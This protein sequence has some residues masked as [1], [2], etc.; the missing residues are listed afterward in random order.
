MEK[1]IKIKDVIVESNIGMGIG[2]M[3]KAMFDK[4][5]GNVRVCTDMTEDQGTLIN[6]EN[7]KW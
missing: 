2:F 1:E 3:A 6:K 4:A 5:K 7:I